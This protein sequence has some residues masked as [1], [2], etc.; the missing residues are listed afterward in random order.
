M[1]KFFLIVLLGQF[2]FGQAIYS[3]RAQ[4]S[5]AMTY[6]AAACGP[7]NGYA[8]MNQTTGV[9]N[10]SV[11]SA[12]NWGANICDWTSIYTVE[13]CGNL[14]GAGTAQAPA[15]FGTTMIRG[16]DLNL[17]GNPA[18]VFET[19]DDPYPNAFE[20]NNTAVIAKSRRKTYMCWCSTRRRAWQR[21]PYPTFPFR[22]L[23]T[24]LTRSQ[25]RY[26]HSR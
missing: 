26:S 18:D 8:C 19:F 22:V 4:H 6:G 25:I 7:G 23:R 11:T 24:G 14:N 2:A 5:G 20:L 15:D 12:P 9:V 21:K 13:K 17:T 1:K 10:F 16:T 3:G